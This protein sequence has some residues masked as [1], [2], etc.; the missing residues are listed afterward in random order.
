[1]SHD[2]LCPVPGPHR[3]RKPTKAEL[4]EARDVITIEHPPSCA[5]RK[6]VYDGCSCG[7]TGILMRLYELGAIVR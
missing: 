1:M 5:W 6:D 7:V 4:E 3:H 2:D